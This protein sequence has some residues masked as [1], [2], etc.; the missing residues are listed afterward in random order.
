[1]YC[2]NNPIIFIDPD[3]RDRIYSA[4]GRFIKDT[5]NGNKLLVRI[6]N[7]DV[8][9]SKLNYNKKGTAYA[10]SRVIANE[11]K[12]I[13]YKGYYGV[14]KMKNDDTVAHTNSQNTVFFNTT[15]LKN[16]SGDN[17]YDMRSTLRHEAD[18]VV[19]HKGPDANTFGGHALVYMNQTK[20]DEFYKSSPENQSS[21]IAG[22]MFR[23]IKA[24]AEGDSVLGGMVSDFNKFHEGNYSIDYNFQGQNYSSFT[25]NDIKNN[26]SF[27][28]NSE[29][30]YKE[31][32]NLKPNE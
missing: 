24:Q 15:Q 3:G 23:A 11:A 31:I 27:S 25:V 12:T 4:S 28:K 10:V 22:F 21:A 7:N 16:G 1:M 20:G 18:P 32:Q 5:G 2:G 30:I 29:E 9:L 13:G 19:G 8:S 17:F 26:T 6:G 14:K